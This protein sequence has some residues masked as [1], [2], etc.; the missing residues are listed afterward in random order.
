LD[1]PFELP[2][3][4]TLELDVAP[5]AWIDERLT[6]Q[7]ATF[8]V[9]ISEVIPTGFA[10]YARIFHPAYAGEGRTKIRWRELARDRGRVVH[11]QMQFEH[12][13]G[14][15]DEVPGMDGPRE[16][17][18]PVDEVDALVEIGSRHTS[19]PDS[20]WFAIWDGY[21]TFAG[22][23]RLIAADQE[24]GRA[25]RRERDERERRRLAAE[26][27][28]RIPRFAIHPNRSGPGAMREYYLFRGPLSAASRLEFNGTS[29]T[30]NLWWP[31]DRAW[32]VA[33]EI[34]GY[35]TYVGGSDACIAS[36]LAD[37]RLESLPTSVDARF[38]VWSDAINPSPPG[39][40]PRWD[41]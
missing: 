29:Q 23:T 12:L 17:H 36:V 22:G 5:A 4:V 1:L 11:P 27:L 9:R 25:R 10:A 39:L 2:A 37:D 20:G 6:R 18:L 7:D 33:T 30:P 19:S 31:D 35:S 16:G 15:L 26:R 40:P 21:A 32:C 28:S 8:G 41:G 13:V 14:V 24:P 3:G 38:D 34:D